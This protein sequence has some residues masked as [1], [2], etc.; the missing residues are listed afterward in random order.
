MIFTNITIESFIEKRNQLFLKS[1]TNVS[2]P[3]DVKILDIFTVEEIFNRF[4][5]NDFIL[6]LAEIL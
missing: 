3:K 2:Y 6:L 4:I 1:M 5:P